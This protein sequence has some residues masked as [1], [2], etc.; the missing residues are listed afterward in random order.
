MIFDSF[1]SKI[2]VR[3]KLIS[4]AVTFKNHYNSGDKHGDSIRYN[5]KYYSPSDYAKEKINYDKV[6]Y[7]TWFMPGLSYTYFKP[8]ESEYLG[9]FSGL[10][11]EYLIFAK[12]GQNDNHGPSH[13]RV[14]SKL[15]ILKSS[16]E[17][18][19]SMFMY[20]VGLDL[21][22][23][24]NPKRSFLV[25]YFGIEFGGM[26]QNQYVSTIQ[27]TPTFGVH[28]LSKK[29][30]YINIQGGYVYPVKNFEMLQGWIGQAG[31]NFALW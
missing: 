2:E 18:I 15:N 9:N 19:N 30:I 11:I 27:L 17:K 14:Y 20:S 5:D 1:N 10:T 16:I 22:L 8:E 25:P 23:E 7:K 31:V 6:N 28:V 26:S 12:V 13:V 24:K 29:N 3:G 4:H 21:S